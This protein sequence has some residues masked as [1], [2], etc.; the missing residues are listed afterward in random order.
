MPEPQIMVIGDINIDAVINASVYPAEGGEA[1]VEQADFRPGGSGFNTSITL[2]KLGARVLHV[3]KIGTDPFGQLAMGYIEKAGLDTELVEI[4]SGLQT[5]F[6]LIVATPTGQRTMFGQRAANASAFDLKRIQSFLPSINWLHI[7]GYTLMNNGQ[8]EIIRQVVDAAHAKGIKIS[9]DPGVCTVNT[10]KSRIMEILPYMEL[11]FPSQNELQGLVGSQSVENGIKQLL[12]LG[13]NAVVYKMGQQGSQ[14]FDASKHFHQPAIH[15]DLPI[16]DTTGA[17]DCFDAGFLFGSMHGLDISDC[18]MLGNLIAYSL[19]TSPHG[20]LDICQK[21]D[22]WED[23]D[24]FYR[25]H[26]GDETHRFKDLFRPT[27]NSASK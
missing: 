14:Y 21:S 11:F 15:S 26:L 6:F 25:T 20:M 17:G 1:V 27:F 24:Q 4:D 12:H 8:W 18:L 22:I 16:Q 2:K 13:V 7:S 9:L 5:G 10:V 19:I 3:G 23:I